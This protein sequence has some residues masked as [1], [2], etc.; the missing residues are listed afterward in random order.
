M[1]TLDQKADIDCEYIVNFINNHENK[2]E[3][4]SM[5]IKGPP[6]DQGFMWCGKEGGS[7]QYWTLGEAQ[8]LKEIGDLVLDKGWDS[9]GYGFM[10]RK[11]QQKIR[12]NQLHYSPSL[13][14]EADL[15]TVTAVPIDDLNY[16]EGKMENDQRTGK[17]NPIYINNLEEG[18]DGRA[19]AQA[20]QKTG[21]G[22]SMDDKN[23]KALKVAS[24]KGFTEAT[25]YM[26]EQAGGDYGR[27]R[28]MYG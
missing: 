25:K 7:G 12:E 11:I 26:M 19:C 20:Y 16:D 18:D 15:P 24:E 3:I 8:G 21:F 5:F 28:S 2:N 27:M 13:F 6:A 23:K 1:S 17:G 22:Q 9:S 4:V 10:M 14:N